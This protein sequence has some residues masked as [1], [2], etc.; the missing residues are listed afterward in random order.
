MILFNNKSHDRKFAA[1]TLLNE[2]LD[3]NDLLA[4]NYNT[5]ELV[6]RMRGAV[7]TIIF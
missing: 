3:C 6:S 4:V 1:V 7:L 5:I 2:Q